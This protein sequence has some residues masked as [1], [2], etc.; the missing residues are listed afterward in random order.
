MEWEKAKNIIL[1]A[2]V[3][4][5]TGLAGLLFF[6][7]RRYTLS[8]E[9]INNINW[10]LS[11]NYINLYTRP[12]R[13]FAPMRHLDIS[14]FYYD[15]PALLDIFFD[16]PQAVTQEEWGERHYVIYSKDEN[17]RI[18]ISNGWV[19][20]DNAY[21]LYENSSSMEA[22]TREDAI[23]ISDEFI[24]THFPDFVR[25]LVF[26]EIGG[27]GVH[28][29]YLQEYRGNLIYSNRI[30]FLVN[31]NGIYWVE[32]Q[33]GRVIGYG[34]EA[35]MIFAPDEVLLTFMQRVWYQAQETPIFIRSMD[36]VYR[37]DYASNQE[38]HVYPAVPF[39]RI[40]VQDND[41][42]FLINAFTNVI[43]E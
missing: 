21:E 33:F 25:D 20:F 22:I 32:M 15:I 13:R 27:N 39:Y 8:D 18:I 11:N 2:F 19:S 35:R 10:V 36:I 41:M 14:G 42:P 6:E 29:R 28:I 4:L 23:A 12:M 38:G 30:E 1:I 37:K 16:N 7:D 24:E 34:P 5:N 31:A 26:N 9:R 17:R 43:S 40:F 3:I